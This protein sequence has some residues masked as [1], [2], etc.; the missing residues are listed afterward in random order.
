MDIVTRSTDSVKRL[1]GSLNGPQRFVLALSFVLMIGLL[2]WGSGSA[3]GDSWRKV[4][5]HE[6]SDAE[7]AEI[8]KT[9]AQKQ[10]PYD[11]QG[12]E[13]RVRAS[14]ADKVILELAGESGLTEK[15]MWK[16]LESTDVFATHGDKDRRWHLSVQRKLEFM[17]RKIDAVSNVSVQITQASEAQQIGFQGPKAS[18]SVLLELK[19][20]QTLA[21]G[22]IPGIARL[23]AGAV[24]GLDPDRVYISDAQGNAYAIPRAGTG[25]SLAIDIRGIEAQ[26]ES[27]LREKIMALFPTCRSMVRVIANNREERLKE[28]LHPKGTAHREEERRVIEESGSDAGVPSI[29]GG[30]DVGPAP[31]RVKKTSVESKTETTL[32]KRVRE[33]YDPMGKIEKV[34]VSVL[35]PVMKD[36]DG[37]DVE[38]PPKMEDIRVAVMN[39][40]GAAQDAVSVLF[41]PTRAPEPIAAVP[42]AERTLEWFFENWTK[43]ALALLGLF[44]LVVVAW[45]IRGG[46]PR[47]EVEEIKA[48]AARLGE[49]LQTAAADPLR[50]AEGDVA[51]LRRG[52]QEAVDRD[53]E[54]AA[55]ALK[56][57]VAGR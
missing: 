49:P 57:W 35:Y 23:V 32:D 26:L 29:K 43:I 38:A 36:R 22:Q 19:P 18:A 9:L 4:A 53:P 10:I 31:A 47:G 46:M 39:V 16:W 2:L 24:K 8:L 11:V 48:I 56:S 6:I 33:Q 45:A 34:S 1:W 40:T 30:G 52:I 15:S 28:E 50:P 55:S 14:Q 13:I 37:K 3:A 7:R 5:G 12:G 17:I 20:G 54:E 25:A 51:A 44:A 42:P 21:R 41:V 27:D